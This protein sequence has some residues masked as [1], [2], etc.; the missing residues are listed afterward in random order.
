MANNKKTKTYKNSSNK[1][2]ILTF[3]TNFFLF[4]ENKLQSKNKKQQTQPLRT[5][6]AL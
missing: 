5:S 3:K 1:I 2:P 6:K 4:K